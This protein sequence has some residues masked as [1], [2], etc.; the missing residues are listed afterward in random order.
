MFHDE[1]IKRQPSCYVHSLTLPEII[2]AHLTD[3]KN[4]HNIWAYILTE[5]IQPKSVFVNVF[6]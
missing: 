5:I 1:Q 4:G 2:L 6:Q 3:T